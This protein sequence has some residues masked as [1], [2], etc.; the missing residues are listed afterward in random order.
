MV[1]I[2]GNKKKTWLKRKLDYDTFIFQQTFRFSR[3]LELTDESILNIIPMSI[4]STREYNNYQPT[5]L[6]KEEY[7]RVI[8]RINTYSESL[9]F[10]HE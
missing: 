8:D 3:D 7:Q 1:L 5:P 6:E 2:I 10:F 9:N 4:S